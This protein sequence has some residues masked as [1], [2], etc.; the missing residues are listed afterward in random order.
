MAEKG[1]DADAMK[2][3]LNWLGLI[4]LA[5]PPV[6]TLQAQLLFPCEQKENVIFGETHGTGLLMDVF[7]PKGKTN[8]LGIVDVASGA[9]HSDRGKIRD[10]ALAQ[11]YTILCARGYTVFAVRP[12]TKTRHTNLTIFEEVKN[13]ADWFDRHL[14][15]E[16]NHR[17]EPAGR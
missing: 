1:R 7:T 9:W 12:G 10:H 17:A 16:L 13:M 15:A 11:L 14:G 4:F 6:G 3:T 5:L 2:A 8:G